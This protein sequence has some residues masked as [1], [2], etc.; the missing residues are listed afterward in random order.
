MTLLTALAYFF[1]GIICIHRTERLV[2][3]IGSALNR[4]SANK[5][6]AWLQGRGVRIFFRFIGVLAMLNAIM[7]L[8]AIIYRR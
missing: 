4:I 2:E 3:W 5:N 8:Y 1:V 7:L 6:R